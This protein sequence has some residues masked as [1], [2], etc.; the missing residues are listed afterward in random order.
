MT[1]TENTGGIMALKEFKQLQSK[2]ID[3][4]K[5]QDNVRQYLGQLSGKLLSGNIL[6]GIALDSASTVDVPHMLGRSYQGWIILDQDGSAIIWRDSGATSDGTKFLPLKTS[7][8]VTVN[9]WVF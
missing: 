7:A 5:V 8:N 6:E 3:L 4:N 9:I 2:D 1:T